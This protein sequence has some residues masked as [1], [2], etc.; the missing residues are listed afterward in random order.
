MILF[1]PFKKATLLVPS[2]PA[3]DP[4]RKHLF[5]LVTGPTQH[6]PEKN[7]LMVSLSSCKPGMYY[8]PSCIIN[9][10]EHPFV[11]KSSFVDYSR[12]R[13]E[14]ADSLIRGVKAGILIPHEQVGDALFERICE[15]LTTSRHTAKRILDF[16]NLALVQERH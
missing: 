7:A 16:Y 2:G 14:C 5:V 15:G 11:R 4:N 6:G 10:G 12:A 13:I 3:S 8:D 9:A 1:L